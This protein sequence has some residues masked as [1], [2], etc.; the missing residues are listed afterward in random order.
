MDTLEN[1]TATLTALAL[2]I[3]QDGEFHNLFRELDGQAEIDEEHCKERCAA[4]CLQ[5]KD[6][7]SVKK[8]GRRLILQDAM[9]ALPLDRLVRR[10]TEEVTE[11]RLIPLEKK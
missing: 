9:D 10:D 3:L 6:K 7:R 8:H 11:Y 2:R 5:L 1:V 4:E